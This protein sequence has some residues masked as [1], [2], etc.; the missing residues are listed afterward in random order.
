MK[1][2]ISLPWYGA[3]LFDGTTRQAEQRRA[4]KANWEGE[5]ARKRRATPKEIAA[6]RV[7]LQAGDCGFRVKRG[8]P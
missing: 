7:I 5:V 8:K 1:W 6:D 3:F 4:D 2:V